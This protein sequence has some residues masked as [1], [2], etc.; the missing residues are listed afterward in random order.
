MDGQYVQLL[1]GRYW[2]NLSDSELAERFG[3]AGA[4]VWVRL[5]RVRIRLRNILVET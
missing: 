4:A 5:H 3:V 1:I 2:Q